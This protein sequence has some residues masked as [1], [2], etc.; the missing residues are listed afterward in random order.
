MLIVSLVAIASEMDCITKDLSHN[1]T[2]GAVYTATIFTYLV[3]GV[4]DSH[5]ELGVF[6]AH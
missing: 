5:E 2:R 3:Q 6:T 1:V 4:G